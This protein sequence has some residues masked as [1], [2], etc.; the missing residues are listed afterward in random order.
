MSNASLIA[1]AVALI[2]AVATPGPAMI[3]VISKGVAQG[4]RPALVAASGVA[5]AD[6][7]LGSLALAGLVAILALFGWVMIV[8]KF[9]GRHLSRSGSASRCGGPCR[10]SARLR[11]RARSDFGAGLAVA[12]GNPKA[13]LF[14]AS[15]MPLI[16]DLRLLD[17][18]SAATILL[19]IFTVNLTVMSGYALLAGRG[20][21]W[22]RTP[23]RL[24]WMNCAAGGSMVGAG[25]AIAAR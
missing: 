23:A 13:I 21:R 16:I 18:S 10:K 3:A 11:T 2:L 25:I 9:A 1:Y 22:L 6:V 15:L 5:V 8:I 7:L 17:W 24:K 14:H 19:I 12:L 20:G 4:T